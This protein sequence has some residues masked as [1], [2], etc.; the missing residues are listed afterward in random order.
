LDSDAANSL[1]SLGDR[2]RVAASIK[3]QQIIAPVFEPF[4]DLLLIKVIAVDRQ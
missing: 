4:S 1:R 3:G 2:H